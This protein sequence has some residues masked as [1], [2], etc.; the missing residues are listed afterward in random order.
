VIVT[1]GPRIGNAES[2][3]WLPSARSPR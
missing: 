2:V 3:R 1:G